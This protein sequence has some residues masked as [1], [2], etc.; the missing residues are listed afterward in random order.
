MADRRY[1]AVRVV[2]IEAASSGFFSIWRITT[3]FC[4]DG[5]HLHIFSQFHQKKNDVWWTEDGN[6]FRTRNMDVEYLF[7]ND[8]ASESRRNLKEIVEGTVLKSLVHAESIGKVSL[9]GG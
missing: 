2:A 7:Q 5:I 4:A 9:R 8:A 3:L 1:T 6:N